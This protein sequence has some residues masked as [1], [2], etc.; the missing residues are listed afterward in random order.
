LTKKVGDGGSSYTPTSSLTLYAKWTDTTKPTIS[1]SPNTQTTYISGGKAVTVNLSDSGSGLK[2]SQPIYYAWSTSNATVPS[3]WSSITSTNAAGAKSASVTVP[4][5]SNSSLTGTYY[6]WIKAGTL[7]DVSGNTS[8]QVVSALFKFDNKNPSLSVSTSKTT[9]SITAVATAS[10]TSGI[11]KYEFSKD[12]GTTWINNGTNKTYTFTG[13]THNTSY[14]IKVRVTSGVSRQN[15]SAVI[16]T[17]TN[18]IPTPTYSSTNN[19]EVVISYPSGCGSTYTCTYIKDGGTPVTV[20]SNPTVYFGANG[21]LVAKV[22]DGVSTVSASAYS[23]V[24]NDLYVSSAGNDTTGYGTINK[25]YATIQKAYDSANTTATIKV[26]NDLSLNTSVQFASNKTITL[27][28]YSTSSS[29]NSIKRVSDTGDYYLIRNDEGTLNL[30]NIIIDGN[31]IASKTGLVIIGKKGILNMENGS[32]VQNANDVY[33]TGGGVRVD[34]GGAVLNLNGG[35][36]INNKAPISA[37][38][39]V[40][41]DS[42]LNINGGLI[43]NNVSSGNAGGIGCHGNL[44]FKSGT[45]SG[46]KAAEFGGGVYFGRY[47]NCS[48]PTFTMSGG[49]ITGNNAKQAGAIVMINDGYF[50]LSGGTITNNT[51]TLGNGGILTESRSGIVLTITGGTV[52]NNVNLNSEIRARDDLSIGT[53]AIISVPNLSSFSGNVEYKVLNKISGKAL[54]VEGGIAENNRNVQIWDYAFNPQQKWNFI[55]SKI[56]NGVVYYMPETSASFSHYLEVY[57]DSSIIASG[58]NVE[59]YSYAKEED[60]YWY[61]T[62]TSDG[63][64]NIKNKFGNYCLEAAGAGT[65]NGTNAQLYTCNGTDA[66]KWGIYF[67]N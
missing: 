58:S 57:G 41:V 39:H 64:Y 56:L 59:I 2:A 20:T 16:A 4:A 8:N 27:T 53:N 40:G 3:S 43:S 33:Y 5:T 25:P 6:L 54:D 28:S 44:N 18:I 42:T 65:A 50:N 22:S 49:T 26:M 63:W 47:E 35:S 10:A 66:Q 1:L 7:S 38:V 17:T 60:Y 24:R 36:I 29:I 11:N 13:L 23:V 55:P 46:N 19:G 15:T 37:G 52:D 14:N 62:L 61:L 48:T 34:D 31:N 12:N 30:K 32:T 51:G 45:I 9:K 21:T 67:A